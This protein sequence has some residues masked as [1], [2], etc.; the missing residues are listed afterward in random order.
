[1]EDTIIKILAGIGILLYVT[2]PYW[3]IIIAYK[4]IQHWWNKP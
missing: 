2:M 3:L 4:L 1:M